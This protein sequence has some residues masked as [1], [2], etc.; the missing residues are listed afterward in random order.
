M[1]LKIATT[2]YF[3][4]PLS[5]FDDFA[6]QVGMIVRTAASYR[7]SLLVFPEYFTCQ[8]L[9][10]FPTGEDMSKSIR[11]LAEYRREFI[12]LMSELASIQEMYIVAGTMP[13]AE[14]SKVFNDSFIFSPEGKFAVQGKIQ[15][16]RFETEEWLVSPR[17]ELK[18]FDTAMGKLAVNICYDVEFAEF[19]RA[20]A[21]AGAR[22]LLVPSC[23]DDRQG[24]LRV[25]YCAH[26]RAI[27]NQLYVIQSSTVGSLPDIP[28][29][30]LNYGQAS[31]LT[32]SDYGFA[33]DGILAQG[34]P[35]QETLVISEIDLDALEEARENGTVRPLLD[36]SRKDT[37]DI[38]AR[39]ESL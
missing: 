22:L 2:Q 37:S 18:V 20:A 35:N 1:K 38:E 13:S 14:D 10:L 19:A 36:R 15:L 9:S 31:V 12:E 3:L 4:R 17:D 33:R 16:T 29:L 6:C 25:R 30:A 24:Y 11:R 27:E 5:S 39:V 32:P 7:V 21:L 28:D 34:E 26:A 23:T 8:L